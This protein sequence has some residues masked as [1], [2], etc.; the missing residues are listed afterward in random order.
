MER[1][2][3]I[4]RQRRLAKGWTI[5]QTARKAGLQKGY[6]CGIE[7]GLFNPPRARKIILLARALGIPEK[8]LLLRAVV[9]RAPSQIRAELERRVFGRPGQRERSKTC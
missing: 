7:R 5:E 1:F 8:E 3:A 6:L 2:G 9:E 4:L